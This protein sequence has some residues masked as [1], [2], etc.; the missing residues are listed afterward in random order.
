MAPHKQTATKAKENA[1]TTPAQERGIVVNVTRLHHPEN[2]GVWFLQEDDGSQ[3]PYFRN[4]SMTEQYRCFCIHD[5]VVVQ[6][7]A[8]APLPIPSVDFSVM[9]L[10]P[11]PAP[12]TIAPQPTTEAPQMQYTT[13]QKQALDC[14]TTMYNRAEQV[15][16]GDSISDSLFYVGYG[17]CDNIPRCKPSG[18]DSDTLSTIKDNLIRRTPSY[19]GNYHYP[20]SCPNNPG[21]V[22]S[23]DSAWGN[24][25]NKWTG[26]YGSL[27]LAQLAELI[28]LVKTVWDDKLGQDQTPAARVGLIAG[29]SLVRVPRRN[30]EIYR[31][32]ADDRSSD[33]YFERIDG[34]DRRS[35]DLRHIV[36]LPMADFENDSRSVADFLEAIKAEQDQA[37]AI[38]AQIEALQKALSATG[39]TIAMLDFGLRTV[40]KVQRLDK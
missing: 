7:P 38:K 12:V 39:T 14:F 17:I 9:G 18:S 24:H 13:L 19:S 37:K 31:F 25:A 8:P 1:M 29:V 16:N 5:V 2:S 35:I 20:V 23:A 28:E 10:T 30:D 27:R 40:H 6:Q 3:F 26:A 15:R 21:D 36:I 33:P 32:V 34:E 4:E 22:D 11:P